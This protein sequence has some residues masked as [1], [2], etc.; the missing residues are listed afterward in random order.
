LEINWEKYW[1][2][3][4]PHPII[5]VLEDVKL[6]SYSSY[7]NEKSDEKCTVKGGQ[8]HPWA[9]TKDVTYIHGSP[10]YKFK[11]TSPRVVLDGYLRDSGS[12]KP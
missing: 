10:V 4:Y 5:N 11:V 6:D 8:Y 3:E 7:K 12:K 1:P 9:K 2:G